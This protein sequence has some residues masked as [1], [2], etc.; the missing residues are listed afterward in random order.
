M[1]Q[2]I[3]VLATK[4]KDPLVTELAHKGYKVT[5]ST[6]GVLWAENEPVTPR[7]V[8][9]PQFGENIG[10]RSRLAL[11]A[12]AIRNVL[13]WA[14]KTGGWTIVADE[15]MWL[16]ENLRLEKELNAIWYQGRT[17]GLSLIAL[18]Q[19]PSRIPRLAFSQATYLFLGK[20]ADKRDIETLRE[21]SS[22]VPKEI[23]E[24][25]IRSLSKENHECLF[26]DAQ[27]DELAIVVAPP[28]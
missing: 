8:V 13:D 14:D 24:S 12:E 27:R 15:T 17:Q 18:A 3:L 1:C 20:F 10:A 23:I 6:D 21:I 19:R 16:H 26:V 7:V 25:G 11:Q 28:R 5:A 4:R 9:W 22:A 2:F